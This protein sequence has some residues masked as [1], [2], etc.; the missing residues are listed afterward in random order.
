MANGPPD[1]RS[2]TGPA[3][4][5]RTCSRVRRR[6]TEMH[7]ARNR[8]PSRALTGWL[9]PRT[10]S[11]C[12][13]TGTPDDPCRDCGRSLEPLVL[14]AVC[15]RCA[16]PLGTEPARK[17]TQAASECASRLCG[18]CFNDPPPFHRVIA[19][20]IFAPPLSGLVHRMKYSRDL[21]AAAALGRMLTGELAAESRHPPP[22]AVIG[23]PLS[24]RRLLARGFNHAEELATIIRREL[25][26]RRPDNARIIRRHAPPQAKAA[27]AAERRANVAGAFT[28]LRWPSNVRRVA[29]VDDVLTTGA[30]ASALSEVLRDQGVEWIEIWCCARTPLT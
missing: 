5:E 15:P 1:S 16:T 27:S 7:G 29:I 9:F 14:R 25:R 26:L 8:S 6:E 4:E 22:D 18:A 30:T 10:C 21:A 11:L 20:W 3:R 12:G 2:G 17:T 24:R 19:P 23:M 13:E 28:V